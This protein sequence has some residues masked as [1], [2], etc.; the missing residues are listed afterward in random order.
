V[1]IFNL[2]RIPA[3][4]VLLLAAVAQSTAAEPSIDMRD[5]AQV[6]QTYLRAIY[7]R[8]FIDAYQFIS[9]EDRKL[10]DLNRYVQQR[11][12]F[13]GFTLLVA[14]KISESIQITVVNKDGPAN[15]ARVEIRYRV[16][17]PNKIAPLVLNWDAFRLNAL[18]DSERSAILAA[19]E[20]KKHDG[21]MEMIEGREKFEL[22]KEG[23]EWRIFLNWA[24]G[25]NIPLRLDL[26]K[27]PELDVRPSRNDIF[28][29]PGEFFDINLKIKNPT[30]RSITVRVAHLVE[31][32][33]VADY[34]DVVQCGFLLPVTIGPGKEQ[35][36]GGTYMLR[37][38]TP[39]GVRQLNLQYDVSV[40]K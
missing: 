34:L 11:G 37:G 26:S 10:R 14:R 30:A 15:R 35:E 17:D 28:V 5:P 4:V 22:V 21:A 12:A 36:Y 8:D 31:P 18:P 1:T 29:Q 3:Q 40:L 25:V 2:A 32:R 9:S 20:G 33:D 24:A 27:A 19:L 7:A 13:T 23:D 6:I 39:E 38:S 16:P